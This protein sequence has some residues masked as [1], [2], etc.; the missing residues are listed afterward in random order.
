MATKTMMTTRM[1][2]RAG[3][4]ALLNFSMP[5]LMPPMTM[6]MVQAMKRTRKRSMLLS[7][8]NSQLKKLLPWPAKPSKPKI[9]TK[10]PR[11]YRRT[12]PPSTA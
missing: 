6:T 5:P 12:M 2:P 11:Q 7:L 4:T 3:M 9:W 1:T 10:K 8:Y